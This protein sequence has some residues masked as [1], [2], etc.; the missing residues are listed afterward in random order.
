MTH[1]APIPPDVAQAMLRQASDPCVL[2]DR[3]LDRVVWSNLA[4]HRIAAAVDVE[5][6]L[7]DILT[8][9]ANGDQRP[10]LVYASATG[11]PRTAEVAAYP[12]VANG[13]PLVAAILI[14][15][16]PPR[17]AAPSDSDCD[18]LTGLPTRSALEAR[19]EQLTNDAE[20]RPFAV[21]FLD[22]D[23][24]KQVNDRWGHVAGDEV[25][26]TIARRLATAVRAG[27]L[28]ARYGGD[29][30]VVLVEGV[31]QPEE[32]QA[33]VRRL[34]QAAEQ[35]IEVQGNCVTLGVSIGSVLS[36]EPPRSARE[37]IATA[38][39][40]MYAEKSERLDAEA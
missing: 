34:R 29:E 6:Q 26:T 23:R 12:F 28:I 18:S 19:I 15:S 4:W 1:D 7:A 38:D 36:S 40:R 10:C 3:Q 20:D 24:F 5:Q 27:D 35:P 11:L 31:R 14:S 32:L 13:R 37:L 39:R 2:F 30:F 22:L 33:V 16:P 25:L 9:P 8:H 17:P 21:L